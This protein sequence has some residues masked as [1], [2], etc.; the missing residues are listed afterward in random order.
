MAGSYNHIVDHE[1]KLISNHVFPC[2]IENLGD[3]YEAIEEMWHMI[4][5]LSN[6]DK[7]LIEKTKEEMYDRFRK[8]YS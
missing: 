3:A 7:Q 1:G 5:I 2:M 4:D 6:G 8:R